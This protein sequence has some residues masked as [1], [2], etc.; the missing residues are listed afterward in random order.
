MRP[1]ITYDESD[2]GPAELLGLR[3]IFCPPF[4]FVVFWLLPSQSRFN[5]AQ[6]LVGVPSWRG[7]WQAESEQ[8]EEI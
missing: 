5:F 2:L 1:R 3:M 4:Q 7:L 6:R 8:L